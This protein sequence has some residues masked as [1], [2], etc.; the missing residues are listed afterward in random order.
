MGDFLAKEASVIVMKD[1][2]GDGNNKFEEFSIFC[3]G[4]KPLVCQSG[5]EKKGKKISYKAYGK[6]K[7]D[8]IAMAIAGLAPQISLM[9][10]VA[11]ESE[12]RESDVFSEEFIQIIKAE[13]PEIILENVRVVVVSDSDSD[14]YI[15]EAFCN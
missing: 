15:A 5:L 4:V 13:T 11:N 9:M 6:T 14:F 7:E 3:S 12:I 10:S 2:R 1:Q 8:A